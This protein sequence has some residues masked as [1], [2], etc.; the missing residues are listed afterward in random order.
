MPEEI[1]QEIVPSKSTRQDIFNFCIEFY[2]KNLTGPTL[3]EVT[4]GVGYI[5]QRSI[6]KSVIYRNLVW[7]SQRNIIELIRGRN[8]RTA[9]RIAICKAEFIFLGHKNIY[10]RSSV[11]KKNVL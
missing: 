3:M 2:R 11:T 6:D 5:Q 9:T 8:R 1:A 4:E 10:L 7:L